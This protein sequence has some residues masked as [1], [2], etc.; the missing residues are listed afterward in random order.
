M[1]K[2]KHLT[3]REQV[4]RQSHSNRLR[5]AVKIIAI[6]V[7]LASLVPLSYFAYYTIVFSIMPM[8]DYDPEKRG[9]E[10][11]SK[12]LKIVE[13]EDECRYT[14]AYYHGGYW[15]VVDDTDAIKKNWNTFVMYKADDEWHKKERLHLFIFRDDY[16]LSHHPLSTFTLFDD[17]CFRGLTKKMTWDEFEAYCKERQI[18]G[19]YIFD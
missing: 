19:I 9:G 10:G 2:K 13:Q 14:L 7:A 8:S 17:R 6:V 3:V 4:R 15:H 1:A 11:F 16:V 5:L 12:P 18:D